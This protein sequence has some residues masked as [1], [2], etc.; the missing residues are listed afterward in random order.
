MLVWITLDRNSSSLDHAFASCKSR[1]ANG[2]SSHGSR[3]KWSFP[4]LLAP[5]PPSFYFLHR[6]LCLYAMIPPD[7]GQFLKTDP[8]CSISRCP[9]S[10]LVL[11]FSESRTQSP[12]GGTS[13]VFPMGV[14][15]SFHDCNLSWAGR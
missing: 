8:E 2:P 9:V 12:G 7:C 1:G 4:L 11:P 6:G 3:R 5:N 14:R 15:K 13:S 10:C